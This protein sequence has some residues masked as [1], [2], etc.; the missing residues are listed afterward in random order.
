MRRSSNIMELP[1]G[2]VLGKGGEYRRVN[3]AN[4]YVESHGKGEPLMLLHG[5]W[6]SVES[7]LN[8]AGDLCH[9]HRL[10]IPER[11]GHGR[12]PDTPGPFSYAQ[13]A[14]DMISLMEEMGIGRSHLLG[15]SAGA[16]V[17]L[18]MVMRR[19]ELFSSFISLSGTFHSNGFS[20]RFIEWQAKASP[21]S[22][23][24]VAVEIY[25]RNS[26]DGPDHL[27][28]FFNKV[29]LQYH[30]H[31]DYSPK[32]LDSLEVPTLI[33]AGD[34]DIVTLDHTTRFFQS[35]P[36]GQLSIIPGTGHRFLMERPGLV[37]PQVRTFLRDHPIE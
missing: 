30:T 8:Q 34:R 3:G 26:P 21:Q 1:D 29:R 5:A 14:E 7:F 23:G 19:P 2:S 35:I 11:R 28:D 37:N 10:I 16:I 32:D 17:G 27:D 15:W 22:L 12:S 33:M 36:I 9:D 25:R 18:I 6:S 24:K 20:D 31:P 4:L 13:G